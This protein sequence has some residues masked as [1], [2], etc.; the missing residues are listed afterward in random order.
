M[1]QDKNIVRFTLVGIT[2]NIFYFAFVHTFNNLFFWSLR[3]TKIFINF[4]SFLR[5]RDHHHFPQKF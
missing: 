5:P 2:E 3:K 1:T 4:P